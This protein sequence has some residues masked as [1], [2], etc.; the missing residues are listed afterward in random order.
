MFWDLEV[1]AALQNIQQICELFLVILHT[2]GLQHALLTGDWFLSFVMGLFIQNRKA[3]YI[4]WFLTHI[5][6]S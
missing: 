3:H 2:D 1:L 4:L 5:K 6:A